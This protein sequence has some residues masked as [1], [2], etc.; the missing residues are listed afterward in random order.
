MVIFGAIMEGTQTGKFFTDLACRLAGKS[1]GG[2]AKVAV[3]SSAFFGSISGVAAANVYATGTFT[4]P[5]MKKLGYRPQ[6]AGAV[7][8]V[9]SSGG[10]Y[11]QPIMG[12]G[13]FVMSE[14]TGIPYLEIC[15]AAVLPALMY[16]ASLVARV[17]FVALRD[18]LRGLTEEEMSVPLSV[19]L[20]DAY[21]LVPLVGLV[22]LLVA[23]YSVFKAAMGAIVTHTGLA[24]GIASLIT[25]WSGGHLQLALIAFVIPYIYVYNQALLLKG[26]LVETVSL[27]LV[28]SIAIIAFSAAYSGFFFKNLKWLYRGIMAA[29]G[30]VLIYACTLRDVV[31]QPIT[32]VA[33]TSSLAAFLLFTAARSRK[34]K[35]IAPDCP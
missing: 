29:A 4:I 12:A 31:G 26:G 17:H 22:A 11:M 1:R 24:L 18:N 30:C 2:P 5:M 19:I 14:I 23:G 33:A 3:I 35:R 25:N 15:I 20:K 32:L 21:L 9:S 8:A 16:Y 27:I 13:V 6:F 7:E 34:M 28:M 10:Q